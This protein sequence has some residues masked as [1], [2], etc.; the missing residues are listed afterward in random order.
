MCCHETT[1]VS[2]QGRHRI[3]N[4]RLA[5]CWPQ[6][7]SWFFLDSLLCICPWFRHWLLHYT[8]G[9]AILVHGVLASP[10][11]LDID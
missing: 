11:H 3:C 5:A 2:I 8:V 7:T 9:I 1:W 6:I 4:I 10:G